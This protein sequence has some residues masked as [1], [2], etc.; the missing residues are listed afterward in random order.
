MDISKTEKEILE[1]QRADPD[2]LLCRHGKKE[3]K[4]C[5]PVCAFDEDGKFRENNWN[6]H[7]MNKVRSLMGQWVPDED[8]APGN[9]WWDD[10]Q[11]YGILFV[12]SFVKEIDSY[13]QGTFIL[14]DWYKSRGKTDSFRI[15]QGDTIREGT[16]ADAQELTKI[17]SIYLDELYSEEGEG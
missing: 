13:L 10:D 9:Y 11:S 14:V 16:E 7:L 8:K 5:D 6:C 17:Y 1:H 15:L 4:G 3:W 2:F 12:P